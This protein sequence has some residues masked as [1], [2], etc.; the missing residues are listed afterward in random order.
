MNSNIL[1]MDYNEFHKLCL[2]A[3]ISYNPH[4]KNIQYSIVGHKLRVRKCEGMPDSLINYWLLRNGVMF[5]EHPAP[6]L[7][8]DGFS[9]QYE[10]LD[11]HNLPNNVP[12]EYMRM[13]NI[14][15]P[16]FLENSEYKEH[17]ARM[18]PDTTYHNYADQNNE[19]KYQYTYKSFKE[20]FEYLKHIG[21]I[22]DPKHEKTNSEIELAH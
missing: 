8:I 4:Y 3:L 13:L 9:M 11:I 2:D 14:L 5:N 7:A 22:I 1:H 19:T 20:I 17:L 16:E 15:F 6:G 12:V 10:N 21:A 18:H